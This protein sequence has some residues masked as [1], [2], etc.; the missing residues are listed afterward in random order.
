MRFVARLVH[1]I[2]LYVSSLHRAGLGRDGSDHAVAIEQC[3]L[4]LADLKP[5]DPQLQRLIV[6]HISLQGSVAYATSGISKL[7]SPVWRDGIALSDAVRS[8]SYGSSKLYLYLHAHPRTR[9][10]LA[11][12]VILIETT[13]PFSLLVPAGIRRLLLLGLFTMHAGIAYFMGL[14]RFFWAFAGFL[15]TMDGYSSRTKRIP[16]RRP[17]RFLC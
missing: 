9:R 6:R 4:A 12:S 15:A 8:R 10:I 14:N 11:W 5:S 17:S 13:A 3:L 7:I 1:I 2:E 16:L